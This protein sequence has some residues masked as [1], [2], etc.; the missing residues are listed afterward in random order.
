MTSLEY[1]SCLYTPKYCVYVCGKKVIVNTNF[2]MNVLISSNVNT[3]DTCEDCG[4]SA[5]YIF[6]EPSDTILI[7][8]NHWKCGYCAAHTAKYI[9]KHYN[10]INKDRSIEESFKNLNI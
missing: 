10:K 4:R 7:N 9:L 2:S 5:S 3:D 8:N 1:L 6:Q